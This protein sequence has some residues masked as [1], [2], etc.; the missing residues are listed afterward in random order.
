M[1][2]YDIGKLFEH[3]DAALK[4][5]ESWK[6]ILNMI[7]DAWGLAEAAAIHPEELNDCTNCKK[8]TLRRL[9]KWT[10]L[11]STGHHPPD[12]DTNDT[13]GRKGSPT[14]LEEAAKPFPF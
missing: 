9:R 7:F 6:A 10:Y 14:E 3:A 8:D 5:D 13:L 4:T 12:P 1:V 11:R 2:Y